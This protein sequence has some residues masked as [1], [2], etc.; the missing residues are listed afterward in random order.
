MKRRSI[1][2]L[3]LTLALV[4]GLGAVSSAAQIQPYANAVKPQLVFSGTTANCYVKVY[5][6]G[7]DIR[8]TLSL[9]YGGTRCG[10][11]YGS[12]TSSVVIDQAKEVTAGYT[13]TLTV[14]GTI[15][16]EPFGP[17]SVTA[18]CG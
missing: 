18:Y 4:L 7:A 3:A 2:A 8:V 11:W 16:G 17:T 5:Q 14:S 13:Y 1:L 6:P 15:N 9:R 10:T 12:G